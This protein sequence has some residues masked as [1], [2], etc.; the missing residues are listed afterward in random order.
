MTEAEILQVELTI[1]QERI[2]A[3]EEELEFRGLRVSYEAA[4]GERACI[5]LPDGNIYLIEKSD[6][7]DCALFVERARKRHINWYPIRCAPEGNEPVYLR[8]NDHRIFLARREGS[9]WIDEASGLLV[10]KG[11]I[12]NW[13][14]PPEKAPFP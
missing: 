5:S 1:A 8:L 11:H 13:A 10:P 3:L 9:Q 14:H 2:H 12:E 7:P 4:E 6:G